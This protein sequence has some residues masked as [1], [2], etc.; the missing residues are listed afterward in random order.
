MA[1]RTEKDRNSGQIEFISSHRPAIAPGDYTIQVVQELAITAPSPIQERYV[2]KARKIRV[3]QPAIRFNPDQVRSVFP[4]EGSLGDHALTLPHIVLT[5]STL[6]WERSGATPAATEVSWL[7]L[8]LFTNEE[9]REVTTPAPVAG[10]DANSPAPAMIEV[11]AGLLKALMPKQEEIKYLT[12]VRQSVDASGKIEGEEVAVVMG[13]R[14]PAG[15]GS[16]AH[17]VSVEKKFTGSDFPPKTMA[18]KERIQLVTLKSWRFAS[19][20]PSQSFAFLLAGLDQRVFRQ[21]DSLHPAANAYLKSGSSLLPH[22][23][24]QGNKSA[25]WYR[26]PLIPGYHALADEVPLPVR[27]ADELV[28]FNETLGLFDVS[29]A[30]AW[31]L[32]RL[33]MLNS[34]GVSL[35]LYHW[36]Q[37]HARKIK[38]AE[39]Q[40]DHLPFDGPSGQ[41]GLPQSVVDWF[42]KIALLEGVPFHNLVADEKLLPTE[43]IR[44]FEVDWRWI[45]CM[46]DGAFSIGRVISP[47]HQRDQILHA[48]HVA[49]PHRRMS[50]VIMRSA[51][52]S[53]WPDL[54]LEA[55]DSVRPNLA[56]ETE[57][58]FETELN[59]FDNLLSGEDFSEQNS[60]TQIRKIFKDHSV[61]LSDQLTIDQRAWFITDDDIPIYELTQRENDQIDVRVRDKEKVFQYAGQIAASLEM[62]IRRGQRSKPLQRA[63]EQIQVELPEELHVVGSRWFLSDNG[64]V[65]YLIER[66]ENKYLV[67]RDYRLPLLRFERL[68]KNVLI[69]IFEGKIRAIDFHLKPE[70]IHHGVHLGESGGYVK[71][72]RNEKGVPQPNVVIDVS[73]RN[74]DKRVIDIVPLVGKLTTST[75]P[76]PSEFALQ[77][78]EGLPK[79]RFLVG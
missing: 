16:V 34:K 44:F 37:A 3:Q 12:H 22:H 17:L 19:V 61:I 72:L 74:T 66:I 25:S 39:S 48:A 35:D 76:E 23:M 64:L 65:N 55:Y 50:G 54:Q 69:A 9:Y 41:L 77:M 49:R 53:G 27:S 31:E 15:G 51:V 32:G 58:L 57:L 18:D 13:H 42:E 26:G 14:L 75:E 38:E 63:F 71:F 4:P 1:S 21:A 28:R 11:P 45:E 46:L 78:V 33:L 5:P 29:Y 6:P 7:V 70:A 30:V 68:S 2:G 8:L 56:A 62:D 43:S 52:V 73:L 36:K 20:D 10:T 67:Y 47:D 79:V 60:L 59:I 24:R 40:I